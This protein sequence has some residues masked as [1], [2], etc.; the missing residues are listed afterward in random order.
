MQD[1]CEVKEMFDRILVAAKLKRR[2][3]KWI[4]TDV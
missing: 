1:T 2:W 4:M 3:I